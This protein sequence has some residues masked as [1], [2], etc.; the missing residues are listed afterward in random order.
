[1][2]ENDDPLG[3]LLGAARRRAKAKKKAEKEEKTDD[4]LGDLLGAA[5]RHKK[6]RAASGPAA[7]RQDTGSRGLNPIDLLDLPRDQC[8][9]LNWL[10]RSEQASVGDMQAALE[11][12]AAALAEM[13]HVLEEAGYVGETQ[14]GG[15]VYYHV[16]LSDEAGRKARRRARADQDEST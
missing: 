1:M 10:L 4:L 14:I 12:D 7:P 16:V 3:D 6:T 5:Q 11:K 8:D 2:S 13:L 15:V 9:L